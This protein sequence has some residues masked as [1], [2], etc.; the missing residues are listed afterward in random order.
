VYDTFGKL[1]SETNSAVDLAF[2][3][4]GKFYDEDSKMNV[5]LNR[6][7]DSRVGRWLSEDPIGF[8]GGDANLTRYVGNTSS[9][10]IDPLGLAG[11]FGEDGSAETTSTSALSD[12]DELQAMTNHSS[13]ALT[14]TSNGD[15]SRGNFER[16]SDGVVLEE[17]VVV[18]GFREW[19]EGQSPNPSLD[20][21][22]RI[23]RGAN[24]IFVPL[25]THWDASGKA[26]DDTIKKLE[27]QG[28]RVK[29]W[30]AL[31]Q[32]GDVFDVEPEGRNQ[33]EGEDAIKQKPGQDGIDE[34][35]DPRLPPRTVFP[36]SETSLY[37][38]LKAKLKTG[39]VS[40]PDAG[41][42]ICND[43]C[44]ALSKAQAAGKI[45]IIIFVHVPEPTDSSPSSTDS[46]ERRKIFIKEVIAFINDLK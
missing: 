18:S 26:I 29:A 6:W 31:G 16:P 5:Y 3:Y 2:G 27:D 32:G 24:A 23:A 46:P 20:E 34:R 21:A 41:E 15:N 13:F 33:R 28:Y 7:Y 22:E 8:D 19:K 14:S 11:G 12:H 38:R 43:M 37:E 40:E 10:M 39:V 1:E 42:F 35:N 4:T 36:L 45:R 30:I 44:V 9:M 25:D 17:V